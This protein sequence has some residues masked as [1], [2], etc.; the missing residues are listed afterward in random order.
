MKLAI[1]VN[2]FPVLSQSFV[3][4]QVQ[5]LDV[6]G[7]D[8]TV[9][10]LTAHHAVNNGEQSQQVDSGDIFSKGKV[11]YLLNKKFL[12]GQQ[13][14]FRYKK[15]LHRM[16]SVS[17]A[18]LNPYNNISQK[19]RIIKSLNWRYGSS[20][21]SLLLASITS[22]VK[23]PLVFDTI[24]A[25]FG[26][27]GVLADKLRDI[28]VLQGK[29]ATIFHGF[30]LSKIRVLADYQQDYQQ[31]FK[32]TE[33]L[34]PIS[35]KWQ[36][37][38]ISL[39]CPAHKIQVHRMGVDLAVFKFKT[40]KSVKDLAASSSQLKHFI[41]EKINEKISDGRSDKFSEDFSTKV[42]TLFT[43]ARFTEKKGITYVL[44]ALALLPKDIKVHYFLAGYGELATQLSAEVTTLG[45]TDSVTLLGPLPQHKV[46]QWLAMS[47]VFIQPSVTAEDGDMEGVPVAL[48]EAMAMGTC[49][50]STYHSGIPELI[51]DGESGLLSQERDA[52]GLAAN[53]TQLYQ[54][55]GLSEHLRKNARRTIE[56]IADV[57][58]LNANLVNILQGLNS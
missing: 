37:K 15:L 7:I 24:V 36:N 38:L 50:I 34:L 49:V 46:S 14:H 9:I 28:G 40:L 20:A 41:N 52:A 31:L 2:Q 26:D 13:G 56:K 54:D 25:H 32:N 39:G 47:D 35:N 48:M 4:N 23:Q 19:R 57:E 12:A 42:L 55:D 51:T 29:I 45:L 21:K 43:V 33:L 18:L 8:I 11:E 44:Q 6:M 30:E 17:W 53:I 3:L 58:K 1:F 5:G 22:Q 16:A 27:C 10:A